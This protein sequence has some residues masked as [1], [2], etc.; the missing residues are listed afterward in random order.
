M[1]KKVIISL[2]NI[3]ILHFWVFSLIIDNAEGRKIKKEVKENEKNHTLY[4]LNRTK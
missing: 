4:C 3:P 2:C 1:H